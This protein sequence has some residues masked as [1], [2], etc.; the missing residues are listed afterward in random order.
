MER[1]GGPA[2][3]GAGALTSAELARQLTLSIVWAAYAVVLVAA[4]LARD[5]RPIRLLA[6]VLFAIT[7]AK[8]F[9]VDLAELDRV[10]RMLSVIGLGLLLL[11]ASYLY[12]RFR[13]APAPAPGDAAPP[14]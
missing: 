3:R 12:Q 5:N 13:A 6:I 9:L 8:V 2:L 11:T 10:Y 14:A 1:L 4:G 7:I